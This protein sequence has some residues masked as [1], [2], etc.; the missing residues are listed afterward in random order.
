MAAL[1][2]G[3]LEGAR[4]AAVS[5]VTPALGDA[6]RA[7]AERF[8]QLA[9]EAGAGLC[10]DVNHRSRLWS[11]DDARAALTPLAERAEVV[12]C[13]RADAE[14]VFGIAHEHPEDALRAFRNDVAPH[15]G[16]VVLTLGGGGA[17]GVAGDGDPV[18]QAAYPA[19]VRDRFGGGDAFMAGLLWG[20]V[21][22]APLDDALQR[23]AALAALKCTVR[24][25][26]ARFTQGEVR[27]VIS[28]P[29]TA[30]LR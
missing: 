29:A 4:F 17:V 11:A 18:H 9:G 12:V 8:A 16:V 25:D 10:I 5:G 21:E 7:Q 30:L 6:G 2:G 26:F 1:D 20:L 22:D 13:S 24:G 19:T 14:A 28:D 27:A 15:S 3:A 23:G